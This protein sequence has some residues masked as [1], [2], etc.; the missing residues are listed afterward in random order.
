MV[1]VVLLTHYSVFFFTPTI[2][3]LDLDE[4]LWTIQFSLTFYSIGVEFHKEKQ[5]GI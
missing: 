2:A 5:Y 4:S 1:K 3:V